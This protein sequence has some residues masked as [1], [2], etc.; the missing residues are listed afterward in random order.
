VVFALALPVVVLSP[1]RP[2]WPAATLLKTAG[3]E[4]SSNPWL[5]RALTVYSVYGSRANSFVPALAALPPGVTTLGFMGVDEP[6]AALW[7]PFGS[8][9]IQ[10]L[11]APDSAESIR[12]R[13]LKYA[14]VNAD[15]LAHN[16]GLDFTT[17]LTRTKAEQLAAMPLKLRAGQPPEDWR[18]VTFPELK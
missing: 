16:R 13:G 10:H 12:Q 15:F 2:L 6:E 11:C 8:R 3:A 7:Q 14:L 1:Q 4:H 5:Q 18:L 17:W 9:R